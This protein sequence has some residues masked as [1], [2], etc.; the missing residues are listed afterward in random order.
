MSCYFLN[1]EHLPITPQLLRRLNQLCW[2]TPRLQVFSGS[3]KEPLAR[4]SALEQRDAIKV[5]PRLSLAKL[6]SSILFGFQPDS[7]MDRREV[8][9]CHREQ[10]SQLLLFPRD[11]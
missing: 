4:L 6:S 2:Y 10:V 11:V 7:G 5:G 9:C 1:L 8:T 3:R